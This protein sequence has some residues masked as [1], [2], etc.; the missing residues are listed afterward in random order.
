MATTP[1]STGSFGNSADELRNVLSVQNHQVRAVLDPTIPI[2]A[3]AES[4]TFDLETLGRPTRIW[5][6]EPA[7]ARQVNDALAKRADRER[8]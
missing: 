6:R 1:R 2:R 8:S 4:G 3:L 5:G 7:V